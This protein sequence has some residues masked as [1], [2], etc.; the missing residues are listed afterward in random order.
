MESLNITI[1]ENATIYVEGNIQNFILLNGILT[2]LYIV[3]VLLPSLLTNGVV[4]AAFAKKEDFRSPLNL[5]IVNQCASGLLSN[6]MNGTLTFVIYPISLYYGTCVVESLMLAST[7]WTQFGI[8]TINIAAISVGIYV[9][10][11]YRD[12]L[13]YK[14]VCVVLAIVWIYP[15]LWSIMLTFIA[16]NIRTVRCFLYTDVVNAP[17]NDENFTLPSGAPYQIALF[18][19]RDLLLDIPS[20]ALIIVFCVASY[21]LFRKSAINP[22]EDL[23][24]KM[25]LLP[26]ITTILSSVVTFIFG[27][28]L[29]TVNNL[30]GVLLDSPADYEDSPLFVFQT[31]FQ[32]LVE[33]TAI[34]YACLLIY[35]NKNLQATYRDTVKRLFRCKRPRNKTRILKVAPLPVQ[36]HP[37]ETQS[38]CVTETTCTC[39]SVLFTSHY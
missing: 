13:S 38:S 19:L 37:T 14:K 39:N 11:K 17:V 4:I 12:R 35:L 32:F 24:R 26:V 6:F 25:L 9:T 18:T 30:Y 16:R 2:P 15:A 36:E 3:F 29:V 22:S 31:I 7:I 33:Y 21:R 5:L 20:R 8:N 1:S 10:L 27:V 28:L 34:A 23:T